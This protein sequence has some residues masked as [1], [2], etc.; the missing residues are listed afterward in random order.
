MT[1]LAGQESAVS[2]SENAFSV[3]LRAIRHGLQLSQAEFAA[4]IRTTGDEIGDPN[5]CTKRL[6]QKWEQGDH[7]GCRPYYHRVLRHITG[8]SYEHLC[9]P[10][11]DADVPCDERIG[12][13][14]TLALIDEIMGQL[15]EVRA[16]LGSSGHTG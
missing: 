6:V 7:A 13:K 15:V 3:R 10:L 5:R 12:D 2:L 9:E 8:I 16:R 1:Q 4:L 14:A 11:Q